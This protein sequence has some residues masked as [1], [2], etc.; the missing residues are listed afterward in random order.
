[1]TSENLQPIQDGRCASNPPPPLRRT[2]TPAPA[3]R[4]QASWTFSIQPAVMPDSL[5]VVCPLPRPCRHSTLQFTFEVSWEQTTKS[6]ENRF[7]RYLDYEY[8]PSSHI[9]SSVHARPLTSSSA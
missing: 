6:F 2:H 9:T 5:S 4:P 3:S 7:D 1:M 8:V